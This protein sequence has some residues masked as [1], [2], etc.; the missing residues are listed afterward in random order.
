[1]LTIRQSNKNATKATRDLKT[2]LR[3][4]GN[5]GTFSRLFKF[6]AKLCVN[7]KKQSYF[8]TTALPLEFVQ[9]EDEYNKLEQLAASLADVNSAAG[10]HPDGK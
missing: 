9:S 7:A 5:T 4:Q 8:V 10:L 3:M 6:E 2:H 1:M